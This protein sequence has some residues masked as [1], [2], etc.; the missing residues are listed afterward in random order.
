MID[1]RKIEDLKPYAKYLCDL[2]IEKC[3]A[4]GITILVTSTLRDAEYQK[5]LYAQGR[6]KPGTIV[7]S[8]PLIGA[9]GFGLA[10]DV[11]PLINGV[12]DWNS[13][14]WN[15]IGVIGKLIGLEWA[16]DWESFVEKCHFQYTQGLTN[17]Q[18]RSGLHPKF[19]PSR[20]NGSYCF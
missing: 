4:E 18:L 6:T 5:S 14:K 2:L 3:K 16:G 10:F 19:P 8:T 20:R 11:V 7:T 17:E 15:R 1:S 12:A 9:H 13:S